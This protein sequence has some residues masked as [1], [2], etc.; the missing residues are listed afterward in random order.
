MGLDT[1]KPQVKWIV[2]IYAKFTTSKYSGTNGTTK[3]T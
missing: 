3:N 1:C 2:L